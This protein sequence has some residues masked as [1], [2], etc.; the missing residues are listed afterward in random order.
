MICL[1]RHQDYLVRGVVDLS[2]VARGATFNTQPP[3]VGPTALLA[4]RVVAHY[5]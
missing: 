3:H 1:N 2:A 5:M 4:A